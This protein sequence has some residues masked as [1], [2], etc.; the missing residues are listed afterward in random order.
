MTSRVSLGGGQ[1]PDALV[2]DGGAEQS[3]PKA[4][5]PNLDASC[6]FPMQCHARRG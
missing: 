4:L 6:L 5:Q 1:V 3:Q 2:R